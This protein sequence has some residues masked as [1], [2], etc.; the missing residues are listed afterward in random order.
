MA[1]IQ[2]YGIKYPFEDKNNENVF[3][4]LNDNQKDCL[5]SQVLHVLFTPKGQRLRNPEF[6]TDLLKYIYD[7]N[8]AVTEDAMI[9]SISIDLKKFVPEVSLD[10]ITVS[11]EEGNEH[12][13]IILVQYSV[14]N[15]NTVEHTAAAIKI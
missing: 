13:K 3:L 8:D 9:K 2:K 12:S 10:K 14:T 4:D 6:G 7:P 15:G 1:V 5:K 11:S